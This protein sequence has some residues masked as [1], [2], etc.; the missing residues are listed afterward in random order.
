MFSDFFL[1]VISSI[2]GILYKPR[3]IFLKPPSSTEEDPHRK[4]LKG[5]H[6]TNQNRTANNVQP[7]MV[8]AESNNK[9]SLTQDKS[10]ESTRN[11]PRQP[12]PQNTREGRAR[13]ESAPGA[14]LRRDPGGP[15]AAAHTLVPTLAAPIDAP[16]AEGHEEVVK[17]TGWGPRKTVPARRSRLHR[18]EY[19]KREGKFA[20][21]AG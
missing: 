10:R 19:T 3:L 6:K 1:L 15:G 11:L 20:V 18:D 13:A 17:G 5:I 7:T 8:T 14:A 16:R 12:L 2:F 9:K 4:Q 21:V